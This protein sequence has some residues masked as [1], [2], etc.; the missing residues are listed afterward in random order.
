MLKSIDKLCSYHSS[1]LGSVGAQIRVCYAGCESP[2]LRLGP[3]EKGPMNGARMLLHCSNTTAYADTTDTSTSVPPTM[4]S[5][6]SLLA[7]IL[8]S[9]Y[10]HHLEILKVPMF[11]LGI[12]GSIKVVNGFHLTTTTE[13]Y[14]CQISLSLSAVR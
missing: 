1:L 4:K 9:N 11:S 2:C 12:P 6:V 13:W 3:G 7:K 5:Y 14:P 10:Q 8:L